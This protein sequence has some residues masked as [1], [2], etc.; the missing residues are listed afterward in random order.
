MVFTVFRLL[1][2]FVCLYTYEFWLSLCKIVRSSVI[3]LLP[4]FYWWRKPEYP[5]KTTDLLQVTDN[6]YHMMLYQVHL[7]MSSA[8]QFIPAPTSP[9]LVRKHFLLANKSMLLARLIKIAIC[10]M[11]F[12]YVFICTKLIMPWMRQKI[13]SWG[14]GICWCHN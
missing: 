14:M 7:T 2:D 11:K 3:L 4:L 13:L 1:T 6:L 5:E 10:T 8:L 12:Q 9:W